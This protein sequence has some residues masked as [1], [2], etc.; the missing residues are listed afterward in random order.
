MPVEHT[1]TIVMID[2]TIL[3]IIA[4]LLLVPSRE[5]LRPSRPA[6]PLPGTD[7]FEQLHCGEAVRAAARQVDAQIFVVSFDHLIGA[8][9]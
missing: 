1:N 9:E 5:P 8:G 2:Q 6:R 7:Q 3:R 4:F